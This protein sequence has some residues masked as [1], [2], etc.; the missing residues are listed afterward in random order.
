MLQPPVPRL[1]SFAVLVLPIVDLALHGPMFF[2]P[3][4]AP[5]RTAAHMLVAELPALS[6]GGPSTTVR[7]ASTHFMS[8]R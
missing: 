6:S 4:E 5:G 2:F 7:A 8:K 1:R 3:I